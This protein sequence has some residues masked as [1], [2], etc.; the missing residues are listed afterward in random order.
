MHINFSF[1]FT[2]SALHL[3]TAQRT[4]GPFLSNCILGNAG[5][6]RRI[7]PTSA[8]EK[9]F[10]FIIIDD[11]VD[12]SSALSFKGKKGECLSSKVRNYSC[13][14]G[15]DVVIIICSI[16]MYLPIQCPD[17][18]PETLILFWLKKRL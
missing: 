7:V 8:E 17:N 12:Q 13:H 6:C 14:T 16:R 1:S 2:E 4:T 15:P 11:I 10:V 18:N 5:H 9:S 3:S